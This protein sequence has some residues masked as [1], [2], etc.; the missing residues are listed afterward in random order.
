MNKPASYAQHFCVCS[1]ATLLCLGTVGASAQVTSGVFSAMLQPT[2]ETPPILTSSAFGNAFLEFD[3]ASSMLC[4]S[5]T[6]SDGGV[7]DLAS[8][9]TVAHVHGP[10]EPG[11]SAPPVFDISPSPPGPS[12]VGS[13]KEGCVGPFSRAQRTALVDGLLYINI[14]SNAFPGGEIRGQILFEQVYP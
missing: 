3:V 6:Y 4:Y 5:I 2:Q 13:P 7:P 12:P 10:A 14:H 11:D 1:I 9:E 8:G